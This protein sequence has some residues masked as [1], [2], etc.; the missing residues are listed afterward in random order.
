MTSKSTKLLSA[1]VLL[2]GLAFVSV[3]SPLQPIADAAS[4]AKQNFDLI[5]PGIS[6]AS[7]INDPEMPN[8]A[9]HLLK[10]NARNPFV[11][12]E[13]ENG[14]SVASKSTVLDIAKRNDESGH[15]VIGAVNLDFFSPNGVPTGLQISDGEVVTAPNLGRTFLAVMPDGSF[16][17]G[18]S[19][20]VST[21][22]RAEDGSALPVYA[23]NKARESRH[24]NHAF[25]YTER[26]GESTLSAGNGVEV[27]IAPGE[28]GA[29]L[30]PGVPVQGTVEAV[31]ETH[32]NAI[33]AGKFVLSASGSRA[34][35]I[36]SHLQV[37]SPVSFDIDLGNGLNE[38]QHAVAGWSG[39]AKVL[40]HNGQIDEGVDDSSVNNVITPNPRSF[41]ATKKG[42]LYVI[43]LDGRLK[44]YADGVSLREG[45]A[46][47]QSLGME[48][49]INI[50]GGG[51]TTFVLREDG[52]KELA[53]MN[54]PSDGFAREI[55]NALLIATTHPHFGE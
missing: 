13:I 38:A 14:G 47:L 10:I 42:E 45:A 15:R 33:P 54:R 34:A 35:W 55:G 16:T 4:E 17:M 6:Y 51:S 37:G 22:V 48:E 8:Q 2:A 21:Y 43:T 19:V 49:A 53:I 44:G 32:N 36:K 9:V 27:L 23:V 46:F 50:D 25:L 3:V 28:H 24:T 26:F 29:K 11:K 31:W 30:K 12:L 20:S 39:L 18:G 41:L 1:L 5:V 7:M 40:L 52:S